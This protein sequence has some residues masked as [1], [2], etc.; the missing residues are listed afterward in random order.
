MSAPET[1]GSCP[2]PFRTYP[3]VLLA[4]GGGGKLM[5][6]LITELFLSG[7]SG[8]GTSVPHDASVFQVPGSKLAFTTDSYVVHPLIFAGGDI[9]SM[10][11]H[12]TVN[13]L[14]MAGARPLMLSA[15]WILEEGLEMSILRQLSDSMR[16]AATLCGVQILTGDTKVVERGKGDGVFINTAGIGLIEHNWSIQPT[17]IRGGDAVLIS[18]D[19]GRHGI[20]I[21]AAREGLSF[22]TA[23]ESDS[24]PVSQ[25]VLAMLRAGI[26]LHCL[27]DVTRGGLTS[28]LNE[29]SEGANAAIEIE[30]NRIPVL[31]EVRSACE[32]LGLDALQVAC[33]GRFVVILPESQAAIALE[34][35]RRFPVSSGAALIG[36]VRAEGAPRVYLRSILGTSR[37]LDMPSGEQLPRIC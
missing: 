22:E 4:H 20:A 7:A 9:A 30:E 23:I 21:M 37:V 3:K 18:G 27:R 1:I 26:E 11:V 25:P 36:K 24:A 12:G 8:T 19:L 6:D 5:H 15:G 35:L 14:A 29:L 10:A 28:V 17:S 16:R 34:T 33:E 13:D 32:I 31:E 2:L